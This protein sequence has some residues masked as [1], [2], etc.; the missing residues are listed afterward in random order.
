MSYNKTPDMDMAKLADKA[1]IKA[2][3]NDA[4]SMI[5]HS[6][7]A[8][9]TAKEEGAAMLKEGKQYIKE[10]AQEDI[11]LAKS[12]IRNNPKKTA[13]AAIIGGY[14]LKRLFSSKK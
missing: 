5:S 11:Q 10:T 3:V 4:K 14:L 2:A 12:Y 1:E 7:K 13:A 9:T 6:A 8:L